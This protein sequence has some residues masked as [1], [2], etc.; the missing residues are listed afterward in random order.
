MAVY[1]SDN[2]FLKDNMVSFSSYITKDIS[3]FPLRFREG[4]QIYFGLDAVY[5]IRKIKPNGQVIVCDLKGD[6]R[7]NRDYYLY[8]KK[9]SKNDLFEINLPTII[10]ESESQRKFVWRIQDLGYTPEEYW[11][12]EYGQLALKSDIGY[13]AMIVTPQP[14]G[15]YYHGLSIY[16]RYSQ[17]DFTQEEI[18]V[19]DHIANLFNVGF[20][21]YLKSN[22]HAMVL[23]LLAN[24]LEQLNIQSCVLNSTFDILFET[25]EFKKHCENI[26]G[27]IQLTDFLGNILDRTEIRQGI[28]YNK[29]YTFSRLSYRI[30][31]KVFQS[32]TVLSAS[33]NQLFYI[34]FIR[35]S[36]QN[37][38]LQD[39]CAPS[40]SKIDLF[41]LTTREKEVASLLSEDIS[42]D[43]IAARLYMAKT[44]VRTHI[45]H[46]YKKLGVASRSAAVAK[47][48]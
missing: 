12:T 27:K 18:E 10:K 29:T 3:Q 48:K 30:I 26:L 34:Q 24:E 13:R 14:L 36:S 45:S 20:L 17:G 33:D 35:L 41:G 11:R 37:A 28:I 1:N 23:Q 5:G 9:L 40:E 7:Y 25:G 6:G 44:T 8:K 16:K 32:Q 19:L 38:L 21:S 22:E 2:H 15:K 4:I 43:E 31:V 39:R 47:L 46:I 42:I